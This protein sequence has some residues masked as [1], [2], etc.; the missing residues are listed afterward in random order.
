MRNMLFFLLLFSCSSPVMDTF[1]SKEL[2]S[3]KGEKIYINSL[4]WGAT[5]DNQ[6]TAISSDKEKVKER[7]DTLEAV[8]GLEPFIYSFKSDSL[9]LFFHNEITFEVKEN[10]KTIHVSY[11]VLRAKEY[12]NIRQ[13]AYN[14]DEY[15][16]VPMREKNVYPS[17]MPKSPSK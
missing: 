17:D 4:N 15:H 5:D 6:I 10:F 9:K 8:K 3:S 13:K 12:N 2:I 7:S 14:N 1:N 16:S 11:I